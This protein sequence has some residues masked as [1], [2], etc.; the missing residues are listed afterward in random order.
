MKEYK[1]SHGNANQ[2]SD[3]CIKKYG[4]MGPAILPPETRQTVAIIT[5]LAISE[6]PIR[7]LIGHHPLSDSQTLGRL[8][9]SNARVVRLCGDPVSRCAV[10]CFGKS[11]RRAG[12]TD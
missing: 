1:G 2:F 6:R 5:T 10:S 7:Q 3:S 11:D 12:K 4:L 8:R 9:D